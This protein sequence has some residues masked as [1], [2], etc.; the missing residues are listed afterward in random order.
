MTARARRPSMPAMYG[1][2]PPP[3]IWPPVL[4]VLNCIALPPP[5]AASPR[6]GCR[7]TSLVISPLI[8]PRERMIAH[9]RPLQLSTPSATLHY[10]LHQRAFLGGLELRGCNALCLLHSLELVV[11][12]DAPGGMRVEL[13]RDGEMRRVLHILA[14]AGSVLEPDEDAVGVLAG[15]PGEVFAHREIHNAR[16]GVPETADRRYKVLDILR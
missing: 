4:R 13:L 16:D 1:S 5:E 12:G 3:P 15:P 2:R 10:R 9:D 14:E 6:R 11:Y 7:T 8:V